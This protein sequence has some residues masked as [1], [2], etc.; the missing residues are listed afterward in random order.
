MC[1]TSRITV[2]CVSSLQLCFIACY[3]ASNHKT[4]HPVVVMYVFSFCNVDAKET[5]SIMVLRRI[6]FIID[7]KPRQV[8]HAD[9]T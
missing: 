5:N 9:E 3:A 8:L 7:K 2:F 6:T 1:V 4:V